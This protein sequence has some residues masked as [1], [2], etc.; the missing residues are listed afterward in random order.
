MRGGVGQK[1][2]LRVLGCEE[3]TEVVGGEEL[4]LDLQGSHGRDL[5][6]VGTWSDFLGTLHL[7]VR[8]L[9]HHSLR[10]GHSHPRLVFSCEVLEEY[11]NLHS[12]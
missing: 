3:A 7:L 11:L 1:C 8:F 4:D 5:S 12:S 2:G 10:T 6:L 9:W